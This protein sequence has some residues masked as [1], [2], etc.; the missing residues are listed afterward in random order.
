MDPIK[1]ITTREILD[2]L[3]KAEAYLKLLELVTLFI[4]DLSRI[5]ILMMLNSNTMQKYLPGDSN[6][7]PYNGDKNIQTETWS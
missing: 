1:T 5:F 7:G 2:L 4:L 6:E 3:L